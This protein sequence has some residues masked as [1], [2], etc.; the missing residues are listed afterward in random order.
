MRTFIRAID[1]LS[2]YAGGL[3]KWFC[4]ALILII[5]YDVTMRYVFNAPTMWAF[6]T[7]MMLGGSLYTFAY[8]YTHL[9]RGHVR[10]D[11]IYVHLPLKA[12]AAIDV[13]G[14]FFLFFPLLGFLIKASFALTWRAWAIGETS[15]ITYWYP[16]LAPFRTVVLLGFCLLALQAVAHFIRDLYTLAG[17]ELHHG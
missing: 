13:L 1:A 12:K 7:S 14:T 4:Y 3:A 5:V 17:K 16:P 9:H 8:S 2:G 10:V 15:D 6:E 11:V